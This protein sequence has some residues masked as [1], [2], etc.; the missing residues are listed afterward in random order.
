MDQLIEILGGT[1]DLV[2]RSVLQSGVA[3]VELD[4]PPKTRL[5]LLV[6]FHFP[7]KSTNEEFAER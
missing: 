3:Q 1:P 5:G 2:N 6:V 7:G 4:G